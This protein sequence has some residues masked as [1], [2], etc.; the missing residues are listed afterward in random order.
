MILHATF[1]VELNYSLNNSFNMLKQLFLRLSV[2]CLLC[3]WLDHAIFAQRFFPNTDL[4]QVSLRCA[5]DTESPNDVFAN[6][7][8]D[9]CSTD[10]WFVT[11]G[12]P[13]I[14]INAVD[15]RHIFV[16]SGFNINVPPDRE[17]DAGGSVSEGVAYRGAFIKNQ[18]YRLNISCWGNADVFNILLANGLTP[19]ISDE[20]KR[21]RKPP[22]LNE[23]Q[24]ILR[25]ENNVK[26][27][28][29]TLEIVFVPKQNFDCLWFFPEDDEIQD[30]SIAGTTSPFEFKINALVCDIPIRRTITSTEISTQFSATSTSNIHN[31]LPPNLTTVMDVNIIPNTTV[32]ILPNV[33]RPSDPKVNIVAGRSILIKPNPALSSS[34]EAMQG[35]VF[36]ARISKDESQCEDACEQFSSWTRYHDMAWRNFVNTCSNDPLINTWVLFDNYPVPYNAFKASVKIFNRWGGIVFQQVF[37]DPNRRGLTRGVIR[38]RPRPEDHLNEVYVAVIIF[39]NCNGEHLLQNNSQ[40]TG[41][42]ISLICTNGVADNESKLQVSNNK[43]GEG[44]ISNSQIDDKMQKVSMPDDSRTNPKIDV[45]PSPTNGIIKIIANTNMQDAIINVRNILGNSEKQFTGNNLFK[46]ELSQYDLS[47]LPSGMYIISV[48]SNNKVISHHKIHKL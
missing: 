3:L 38:W 37:E 48:I 16:G 35:S 19:P 46:N 8:G 12:S 24:A 11:H 23:K 31:S 5:D 15:G 14:H 9:R 43:I 21:I 10:P 33:G 27:E 17:E 26:F 2:I 32:K 34:F 22:I 42:D 40:G 45:F 39:E 7:D 29:K 47:D 6:L 41:I 44:L 13:D 30:M 20:S 36:S 28:K 4:S 18:R 1:A 25:F